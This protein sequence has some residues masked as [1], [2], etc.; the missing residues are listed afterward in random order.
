MAGRVCVR[1]EGHFLRNYSSHVLKRTIDEE[2]EHQHEGARLGEVVDEHRVEKARRP[3]SPR[4]G[5]RQFLGWSPANFRDGRPPVFGLAALRRGVRVR[6]C[7]PGVGMLQCR[8]A[9]ATVV[10]PQR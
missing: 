10:L 5:A 6:L 1:K 8:V 7:L 3:A 9:Q 2:G 4:V